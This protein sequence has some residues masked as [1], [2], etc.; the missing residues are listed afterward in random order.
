MHTGFS[1]L[2]HVKFSRDLTQVTEPGRF[3]LWIR[4]FGSLRFVD[5]FRIKYARK[6]QS[7][8]AYFIAQTF[9]TNAY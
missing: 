8:N 3:N 9:L 4:P 6:Y 1:L 7:K 5:I 2:Y